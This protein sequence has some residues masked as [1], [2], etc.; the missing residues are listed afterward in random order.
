MIVIP[1]KEGEDPGNPADSKYQ[2]VKLT[3]EN[4]EK[5]KPYVTAE[6]ARK[7]DSRTEFPVGDGKYYSRASGITESKRK[8]RAV[9]SRKLT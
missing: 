4:K 1:L 9:S 5:S 2:N 7:D 8:R 6:F 3:Y